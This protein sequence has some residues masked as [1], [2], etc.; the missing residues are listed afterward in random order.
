MLLL[1]QHDGRHLG[2][3]FF[4]VIL[5]HQQRLEALDQ[6]TRFEE[7]L[8]GLDDLVD[9]VGGKTEVL[10]DEQAVVG[11]E[12]SVGQFEVK[13]PVPDAVGNLT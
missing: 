12:D 4:C 3:Q 10:R 6:F 11:G 13:Q 5:G 9:A 8:M 1:T 2:A 7:L